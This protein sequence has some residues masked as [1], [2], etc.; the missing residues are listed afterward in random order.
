M[1]KKLFT[2]LLG[3][4]AFFAAYAQTSVVKGTVIDKDGD[5]L[6]GVSIYEKGRHSVSTTTDIE[7]NYSISVP[8]NATLEFA[9]V[10]YK[11]V[12]VDVNGR[13]QI[14]VTLADET[15]DLSEIVVV[16]Y[17]VQKRSSMTASVASVSAKEMNKQIASNVAST[18]QGRAPG[19]EVLQ[20]GADP[21]SD[22]SILVRGAGS[23][24]STEPLY[25]IDGAISNNGLSSLVASDIESIEVLK[26][27]SAAAIYG[28]RAANGV[29]LVTTKNG[30]AGE[31]KVELNGSYTL[32]TPA[33]LLKFMNASQWREY[34][35]MVCDNSA[36]YDRATQNVNPTDPDYST[37]W[38]DIYYNN[39][40]MYSLGA[41]ISGGNE[42]ATFNTS[43]GY[44]D[45][46]G[47]VINSGYKKYNARLNS[48]YKKGRFTIT[49]NL[50]LSHS[51]RL[52]T[53]TTRGIMIPTIPVTDEYGRYISTPSELGYSTTN[54]NITPPLASIYNT[55][56]FTKKT[57]V[58]GA[59]GVLVDI[60][61]GIKYKFNISGDYLHTYGYAH[62][63]EYATYWD[64]DG[65]IDSRFSQPYTYLS[66]S[67]S[68][69]FNYTI[70]NLLTF[71]RD[72]GE[73][74][75]DVLL[76]T[77]WMREYYRYMSMNSGSNDLGAPTITT[78]N[79]AG[80]IGSDEQNSAL[81]SFFG[82]VNYNYAE[83][84]LLSATIRRDESSKFAKDYR[85]GYF[86]SISAGWNIHN[87]SWFNVSPT[88]I[89]KLKIRG[90][91]GELGANFIDPYS[92]TS[93]A[94][95]PV[96]A[97]FG[98]QRVFGYVTKLA[99][100]N[101]KWETAVSSNV[102]V[103]MAFL[104]NRLNASVEYYYR[105]NNDLLAPLE[106]LPSSG[107]TI[108]I[109]DGDLPYFNTASVENKGIEITAGY[110]DTFGDWTI[111]IDGNITFLK[112]KVLKLGE[113]VQPIR[114]TIMS[115]KFND[116]RQ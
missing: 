98:D 91:Y 43:L 92:F 44:T 47:I 1:N 37:D 71:N 115:S 84:Y 16:G 28:S 86:P 39:A 11:T 83:R 23:F 40:S 32:Q 60:W 10:G 62:T 108:I 41:A 66:E 18:L 17:G 81:L 114:G 104:K 97:I 59:L 93:L 54:S 65:N 90:S 36:A 3:I 69:K 113:G 51:K 52:P 8:Q 7:G 102:G 46:D 25:I 106:P 101:L 95:G 5:P 68:D 63:P 6:I 19:V 88:I 85:V 9:Y 107:Q 55:E 111:G 100:Q 29:V 67:R 56:Q 61:G 33:K 45:Q 73:H 64:A 24:G 20:N 89:N 74:S 76:G 50:S 87:E 75:F 14:N 34:A 109:N 2:L 31:T 77:S 82:R 94:Y 15:T 21:G 27:G 99:Q 112:N 12:L 116:A 70:D 53:T 57:D 35:N 42:N 30:K 58:I 72:F 4:F 26:D 48:T 80:Q 79:G 38:Q 105:R 13:T 78:Y 22:I 49:E 110:R 103:E 96:P